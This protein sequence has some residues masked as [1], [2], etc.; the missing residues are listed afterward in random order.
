MTA[1]EFINENY[2]PING[3]KNYMCNRSGQLFSVEEIAEKYHQ[4]KL[5]ILATAN[6]KCNCG[7][8]YKNTKKSDISY[9]TDNNTHYTDIMI[10]HCPQ[11]GNIDRVE[12]Y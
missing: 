1:T 2:T 9:D 10:I 8:E 3:N 5:K 7:V 11:C 4:A 6:I 12:E